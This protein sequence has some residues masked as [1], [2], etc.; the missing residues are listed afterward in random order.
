MPST[1]NQTASTARPAPTR[2]SRSPGVAR[3]G[4]LLGAGQVTPRELTE[5]YL[6][7]IERLDPALGAFISVRAER[8]LDR[9]RRGA[10]A[11]ARRGARAAARDPDRD[12]GQRRPRRRGHDARQPRSTSGRDA[13]TPR[14]SVACARAGAVVLGK[15]ALCELAAWGHFTASAALRRHPQPVEPR[16]AA[17]AAP[18]A[19]APRRSPPAWCRSRSDPTAAAR[20]GSR[21]RSAACSASSRSAAGCRSRR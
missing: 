9:G 11:A 6:A 16:S 13:R 1:H 8:A 2:I 3:L 20:S 21:R 12:Q 4:E 15:T 18:A 5:F 7:R 17:R 19:A 14:S 10:E